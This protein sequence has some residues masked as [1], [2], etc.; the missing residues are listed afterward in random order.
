MCVFINPFFF[1][2]QLPWETKDDA[3]KCAG[4]L[5]W[6]KETSEA[7][8]RRTNKQIEQKNSE[9]TGF[10]FVFLFVRW[11]LTIVHSVVIQPNLDFWISRGFFLL[12][13]DVRS[14]FL[15]YFSH[16]GRREEMF[17]FDCL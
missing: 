13:W 16:R 5:N 6:K 1:T 17:S 14:G 4:L 2:F 15:I 8:Q 12:P 10:V 11:D 3:V 9:E 7:T